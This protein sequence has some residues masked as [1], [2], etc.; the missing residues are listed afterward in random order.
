M[1][2]KIYHSDKIKYL[3]IWKAD[4]VIFKN[5]TIGR[6]FSYRSD[7]DF[8]SY[9]TEA[10]LKAKVDDLKEVGYYYANTVEDPKLSDLK[11]DIQAWMTNRSISFELSNTKEELLEI[12][13]GN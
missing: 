5:L 4:N 11:A 3:C 1:T 7:F 6:R 13:N 12:I 2:I 10:E 8:A 9:D